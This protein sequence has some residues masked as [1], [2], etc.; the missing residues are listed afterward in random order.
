[1]KNTIKVKI[2]PDTND[3]YFD[4]QDFSNL[5]EVSQVV[6]YELTNEDNGSLTIKFFDKNRKLLANKKP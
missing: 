6:Y 5:V 2:D 3:S 1:M 4:L